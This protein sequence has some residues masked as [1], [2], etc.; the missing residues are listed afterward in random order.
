MLVSIIMLFTVCWGPSLIDNVLIAFG[1]VNRLNYGNLKYMRQ[2]FSLMSYFNSCVNPIVYAF[3]SKNFRDSFRY[4]L[5][6]CCCRWRGRWY[7]HGAW[8]RSRPHEAGRVWKSSFPSRYGPS[9]IG[10]GNGMGAGGQS[11]YMSNQYSCPSTMYA[12]VLDT[13]EEGNGQNRKT[14][15]CTTPI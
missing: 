5:C 13:P 11:M 2:A 6:L 14:N 15:C 7:K 9:N 8:V 4:A 1:Q 3:M 10:A 12:M